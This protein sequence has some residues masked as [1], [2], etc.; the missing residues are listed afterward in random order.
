MVYFKRAEFWH[1]TGSS[2]G[3]GRCLALWKAGAGQG[4]DYNDEGHA[5]DLAPPDR[6]RNP[7]T[8]VS[9]WSRRPRSRRP[10]AEAL[11]Y[12]L[13]ESWVLSSFVFL[14]TT[15]PFPVSIA[16]FIAKDRNKFRDEKLL[17][18]EVHGT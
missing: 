11:A 13:L 10:C 4:A 6:D 17:A 9:C 2:I 1:R 14:D 7:L 12:K 3:A 8:R 16:R 18:R 5:P 15:G